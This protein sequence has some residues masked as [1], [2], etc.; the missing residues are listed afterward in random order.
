LRV[1]IHIACLN[2]KCED[3]LSGTL[4]SDFPAAENTITEIFLLPLTIG[5]VD[6]QAAVTK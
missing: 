1:H 2:G 4:I 5:G 6:L 3:N